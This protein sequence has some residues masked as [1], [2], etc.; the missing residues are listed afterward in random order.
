MSRS[1]SVISHSSSW[2]SAKIVVHLRD[3][4]ARCSFGGVGVGQRARRGL[5]RV[6]DHHQRRLA[7]LRLGAR[8][9]V[10][11]LVDGRRVL[12]ALLL[13]PR[14]VEEVAHQPRAVVLR[15]GVRH[16]LGSRYWRAISSPS[17][18][19]RLMITALI[20][21]A[22]LVVPV[23]A[24]LVLAE[25]ERVPAL[26]DVVVV[27]AR[28][29]RAAGW[30]RWPRAAASTS[31]PDDDAVVVGARRLDDELL[32]RRV[33]EVG[34][35]QQLDVRGVAE[36]RLEQRRDEQRAERQEERA[37]GHAA[38]HGGERLQAPE[39]SLEEREGG[40][41]HRRGEAG[42]EPGA[43]HGPLAAGM[44]DAVGGNHSRHQRRD[45][46]LERAAREQAA[47]RR[48]HRGPEQ[49]RLAVDEEAH[50]QRAERPG[51]GGGERLRH[52]GGVTGGEPI[53]HHVVQRIRPEEAAL[54]QEEL[55]DEQAARAAPR[56][57]C[58][59]GTCARCGGRT[60]TPP[61]RGAPRTA[62]LPSGPAPTRRRGRQH[63]GHGR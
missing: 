32:E 57:G 11:R 27:R 2:P 38:Q 25:V 35:L 42:E 5:H 28:A 22:Q 55:S 34:Q 45:R 37:A 18:T 61:R 49:R 26:A 9:A 21:G 12:L 54:H 51:N 44:A 41:H 59:G 48:E 15:D 29:A 47:E 17:V 30:R 63:A 14:L 4:P 31:C 52:V 19:W 60:R 24:L 36:D 56:R 8:I 23:L 33:V 16:R 3:R 13:L 40:E 53:A 7:E 58:A 39:P 50:E 1:R 62:R 46:D 43:E 20:A 6:G 10:H